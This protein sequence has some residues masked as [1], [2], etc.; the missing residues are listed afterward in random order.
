MPNGDPVWKRP[1]YFDR[2]EFTNLSA[3]PQ[4]LTGLHFEFKDELDNVIWA[5]DF[6]GPPEPL[7]IGQGWDA[8]PQPT[9]WTITP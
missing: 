3:S 5:V 7:P 6:Q 2:F 8:V 4:T 1:G 9:D